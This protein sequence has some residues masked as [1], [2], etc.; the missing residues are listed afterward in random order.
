MYIEA[1][2]AVLNQH[3][4]GRYNLDEQHEP[5]LRD[6]N[7]AEPNLV[8]D[9][10]NKTVISK[11]NI[12]TNLFRNETSDEKLHCLAVCNGIYFGFMKQVCVFSVQIK[13]N[14]KPVMYVIK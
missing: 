9:D 6:T 8:D 2:R 7:L 1:K 14:T 13:F 10:K 5:Q 4:G 3:R 11:S 12:V